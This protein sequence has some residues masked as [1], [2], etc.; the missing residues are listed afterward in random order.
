MPSRIKSEGTCYCHLRLTSLGRNS[1]KF[2]DVGIRIQSLLWFSRYVVG[3]GHPFLMSRGANDLVTR[4][5][6]IKPRTIPRTNTTF[7]SIQGITEHNGSL[8]T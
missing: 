5:L 8:T 1:V 4:E 3:N 6:T 2:M 7:H